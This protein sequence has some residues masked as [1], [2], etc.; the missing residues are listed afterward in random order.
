MKTNDSYGSFNGPAEVR[1]VRTLPGPIERIWQYLTDPAKRARWFAGGSCE[2][3]A[4][5][6]NDLVFKHQNLSPDEEPP[7]QYKQMNAEGF[8]MPSTILR[9]EPPRLLSYTFDDSSEVTFELTPQGDQ[10]ILVL[11]HRARGEDIP[12]IPGYASG[13]HTHFSLLAALLEDT[14]PPPFWA[15]HKQL[16]AEYQKLYTDAQ[17][18]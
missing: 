7:E 8:T 18:A 13:W 2:P 11:T 6:K 17:N 5:G 14:T 15:L 1:L 10:V 12:S 3:K 16:K 9:F 4:G